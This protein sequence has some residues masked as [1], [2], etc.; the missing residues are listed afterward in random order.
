MST[1]VCLL[2][3]SL[4]FPRLGETA[5]DL[6]FYRVREDLNWASISPAIFGLVFESALD[7]EVRR[8]SG[9]YCISI[10]N[11]RKDIDPLF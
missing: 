11:I 2:M 8:A 4:L 9:M 3:E 7:L 1:A 6:I 5:L 10:E